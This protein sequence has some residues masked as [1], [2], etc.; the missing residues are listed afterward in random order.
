MTY[1]F[2]FLGEFGYELMN[3]QGVVRKFK[4]NCSKDEFVISCSRAN[5]LPLYEECDEYIDISENTLFK[6]S[7]AC[8][9]V[10][11]IPQHSSSDYA[12]TIKSPLKAFYP[13]FNT[14]EDLEYDKLLKDDLKAYILNKMSDKYKSDVKFIF[15]SEN[16]EIKGCKF[17]CDRI[18]FDFNNHDGNIYEHL[19]IQNNVYKKINC[20]KEV[21][22]NLKKKI[23]LKDRPFILIQDAKRDIV[24]RSKET[25]NKELLIKKLSEIYDIVL[26]S[27][28]T[29]RNKDSFSE[30]KKINNTYEYECN[31]F[32]EQTCLIS[33]AETCIFFTEGDFR[34]H[35]YVPPFVGK[36]VYA[37]APEDVYTLNTSPVEFWN[38]N[39]FR[40]D[41]NIKCYT[42]KFLYDT[43]KIEE[44][45]DAINKNAN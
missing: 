24:Q 12:L 39:V 5:T 44:F 15:S 38:K 26:L 28:K 32:T 42:N 19:D 45:V 31:S 35:I 9:Y 17:G 14:K 4:S 20:S 16:T 7:V 25:S 13:Q 22:N 37:I 30:F 1:V 23:G 27:F 33:M 41:G 34:S 11:M 18:T 40:F 10:G 3:W 36:D 21:C 8:G 29:G 2:V 6:N 43:N